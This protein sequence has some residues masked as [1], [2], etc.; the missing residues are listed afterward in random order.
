MHALILKA[1]HF[2]LYNIFAQWCTTKYTY[3]IYH[4]LS[5]TRMYIDHHCWTIHPDLAGPSKQI[6]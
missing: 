3:I 2:N 1:H 4:Q 5:F 6:L